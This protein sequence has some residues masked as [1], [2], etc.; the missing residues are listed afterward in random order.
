MRMRERWVEGVCDLA[1][2]VCISRV[3]LQRVKT[4]VEIM[5]AERADLSSA[6]LHCIVA[7]MW[8]GTG[9]KERNQSVP[10]LEGL[11]GWKRLGGWREEDAEGN[12]LGSL[13][14]VEGEEEELMSN[15]SALLVF[16]LELILQLPNITNITTGG[17]V[18]S[19]LS[20]EAKVYSVIK[21]LN[22]NALE[23]HP[24][25]LC[26]LRRVIW[27]QRMT[28][29]SHSVSGCHTITGFWKRFEKSQTK[30]LVL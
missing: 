17:P 4:E 26:I 6:F 28:H 7:W 29:S 13:D 8:R 21:V 18:T 5:R 12:G 15:F 20:L 25:V 27:R 14:M 9:V 24:E 1:Q 16:C 22:N 23:G 19:L 10:A 30:N 11:A 2:G 3:W